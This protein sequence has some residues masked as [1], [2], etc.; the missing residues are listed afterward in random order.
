MLV[1]SWLHRAAAARPDH[2]ALVTA[3]RTLS[4]AKLLDAVAGADLPAGPG[5]NVALALPPG[6]AFTVA[7]HACLL[8]GAVAVPVDPRLGKAERARREGACAVVVRE[9]LP[10]GRAPARARVAPTHD[11]AA[12]AL[13]VHTSGSTDAGTPVALT[14][15]NWLWSALGSSVALGHPRDERWLCTLPLSHVGGLSVLLRAVIGATTVILHER[16][17]TRAVLEELARPDGATAVSLVPTTLQRLLDG[18]L[19]HPAALRTA[20]LGGAPVPP[21]LLD[22]SRDAGV[23]AVTTYGLTEACSQVATAGVPLFCT[24]VRIADDGE[25]LVSGPTVAPGA[26]GPDG[27][28]RTG[29]LGEM[30]SDGTLVVTGRAA[31]TI[32]TGGENVAPTDVEAVLERHPAV[33]EAAVHGRPDPEWGEAVVATVVLRVPATDT[34]LIAHC[35]LHLAPFQAPKSITFAHALPRTPSGKVRRPALRADSAWRGGDPSAG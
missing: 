9:A 13:V 32:V 35:A 31:D 16:F 22:R 18:G 7:L 8:A 21:A 33:A 2:P 12:T 20:L 30:R 28:L 23:P 14:Y 17:D 34:E 10:A 1:E 26:A 19:H 24:R 4:Y 15:A 11:L 29:D 25:V 5:D 3:Q 6:E 27:W